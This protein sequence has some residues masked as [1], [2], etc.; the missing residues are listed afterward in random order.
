MSVEGFF[1]DACVAQGIKDLSSEQHMFSSDVIPH[2]ASDD[3][4][5]EEAKKRN[6]IVVTKDIGFIVKTLIKNE[7]IVFQTKD[8][9]RILLAGKLIDED[10]PHRS[11]GKKTK[12]LLKNNEIVVP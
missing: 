10:C 6:R 9:K 5:F 2:N 8:G 1:L 11:V 7:S 12:Y 3:T 4:V